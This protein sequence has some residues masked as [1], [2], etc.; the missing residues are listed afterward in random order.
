MGG[1]A[2]FLALTGSFVKLAIASSVVRLLGYIIC[3]ASL[4][5]IRRNA[6]EAVRQKA[7]RLKGGY[8]I[9]LLGLLVCIWLLMQSTAEAWIA[10]SIL[11]GIGLFLYWLE[12]RTGLTE[13]DAD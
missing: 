1:M 10:V 4:P 3:I 9:P 8:A 11:V 7:L 5:A 6:S 2:L 13:A 12:Q